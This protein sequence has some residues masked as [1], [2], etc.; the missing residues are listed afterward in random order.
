V[1]TYIALSLAA[2]GFATWVERD[3]FLVTRAQE[4]GRKK[5]EGWG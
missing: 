3:A 1:G 2:G 5:K 4:V